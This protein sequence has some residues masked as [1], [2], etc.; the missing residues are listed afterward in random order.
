MLDTSVQ[1]M[2]SQA[3]DI[4]SR[5]PAS[6]LD[7]FEQIADRLASDDD[8]ASGDHDLLRSVTPAEARQLHA[9]LL[10]MREGDEIRRTNLKSDLD[11]FMRSR[12]DRDAAAEDEKSSQAG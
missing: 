8:G 1:A 9:A 3:V 12:E 11:S 5:I 2:L 10:L 7:E 6:K 4:Y